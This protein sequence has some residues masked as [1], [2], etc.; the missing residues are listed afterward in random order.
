MIGGDISNESPP[1][2]IV[3]VD[4]VAVSELVENKRLLRGN[5]ME[6]KV[7]SLNNLALS[8]LWNISAQYG[9]SV[10]LAG[11]ADDLWNQEHL[12][13][14]MA[15]LDSRGGNPFNYAE[16]YDDIPNFVSELPYRSNLKGVVDL[17]ERVAR[18]GSWGIELNNL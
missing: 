11:F 5:F 1:R 9:L 6:R 12:D 8:R 17:Q 7:T 4:V 10:E 13:K 14:L 18:Y 2:I 3:T 16:L 15:R